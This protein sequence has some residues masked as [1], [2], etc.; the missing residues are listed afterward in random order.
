[1][2]VGEETEADFS[3]TNP[4]DVPLTDCFLTMEISGSVRPRTI[5]INRLELYI[6]LNLLI[7]FL[8]EQNSIGKS[9]CKFEYNC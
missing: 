9:F 6:K 7:G 4:L 5:R 2:K 1:M 8:V 3:F